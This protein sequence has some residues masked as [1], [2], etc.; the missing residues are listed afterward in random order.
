MTDNYPGKGI[1]NKDKNSLADE[2]EYRPH[3]CDH[4]LEN[5]EPKIKE[6]P[7][8]GLSNN[9]HPYGCHEDWDKCYECID[10]YKELHPKQEVKPP[11]VHK[12]VPLCDQLNNKHIG[13]HRAMSLEGRSVEKYKVNTTA[14]QV[15][16]KV[17]KGADQTKIQA[18]KVTRKA[19][20]QLKKRRVLERH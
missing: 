3:F 19:G 9:K 5:Y 12:C 6:E 8:Q 15:K 16:N 14:R 17:K 7:K 4:Q 13:I 20:T 1:E 18:K 11:K 2:H 10:K